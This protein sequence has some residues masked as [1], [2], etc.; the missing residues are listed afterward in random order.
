MIVN[1]IFDNTALAE[2]NRN[3][4]TTWT[5]SKAEYLLVSTLKVKLKVTLVSQ[6]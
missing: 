1:K 3:Y 6:F 4:T 2:I 5:V